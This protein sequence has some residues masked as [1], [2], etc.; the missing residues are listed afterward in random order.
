MRFM[1]GSVY[2]S[3]RYIN[4]LGFWH[5]TATTIAGMPTTHPR[6]Y[7]VRK[8]ISYLAAHL[9]AS[10]KEKKNYTPSPPCICLFACLFALEMFSSLPISAAVFFFRVF[11]ITHT[12]KGKVKR[13]SKIAFQEAIDVC[14]RFKSL[15]T[16][17][18]QE[19]RQL[20]LRLLSTN[21]SQTIS[22]SLF[23][24]SLVPSFLLFF[25]SV[26]RLNIIKNSDI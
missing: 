23:F 5:C 25:Y 1:P 15:P 10:I 12:V 18:I 17:S 11:M 8:R 21:L 13:H 26:T 14:N 3:N 22:C 19:R 9:K 20:E 6:Y 4:S 24:F 7:K 16:Q 2:L